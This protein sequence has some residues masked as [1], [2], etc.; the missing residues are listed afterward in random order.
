VSSQVYITEIF[1]FSIAFILIFAAIGKLKTFHE[2]RKN[3][4]ESFGL[5]VF[6]SQKIAP[7]IIAVELLL[8]GVILLNIKASYLGMAVSLGL[9]VIFT[10]VVSYQY[11]KEGIVKCSCFGESERSVSV[12]DLLRNLLIIVCILFYLLCSTGPV[13]H[14]VQ[15]NFLISGLAIIITIFVTQFHEIITLLFRQE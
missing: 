12:Y 4:T 5:S 3:L 2:F 6:A 15:M 1:R 11:L 10:G 13:H 9:F 14:D 8:A 7:L